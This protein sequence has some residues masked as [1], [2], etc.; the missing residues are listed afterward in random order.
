MS[1]RSPQSDETPTDAAPL[2]DDRRPLEELLASR[3][4]LAEAQRIARVGSWDWNIAEGSLVWSDEIY[5]IFGLEPQQFGATYEA[6]LEYVHSD[7]REKVEQAV[8]AALKDAAHYS[9]EHRVVRPDGEERVVHERGEVQFD[10]AG[11]PVHM[12]GTVQDITERKRLEKEREVEEPKAREEELQ[13]LNERLAESDRR[14]RR[15]IEANVA[16]IFVVEDDHLLEANDAFLGMVGYS[17]EDMESGRLDW[18]AMTPPEWAHTIEPG[19]EQLIT[20]GSTKP[21][22]KEYFRKDGS[23]VPILLGATLLDL[24]PLRWMCFVLDLSERKAAE[25]ERER[26]LTRTQALQKL[27]AGLALAVSPRDVLDVAMTS[28]LAALGADGGSL[29]LLSDDGQRVEA[30]YVGLSEE[31]AAT[32]AVYPIDSPLP[33]ATS[34]KENIAIWLESLE[35]T[36]AEYPETVEVLKATGSEA[37]ISLPLETDGKAFGFLGARFREARRF[38]E[39]DRALALTLAEQCSQ[40]LARA[41]LFEERQQALVRSRALQEVSAGLATSV[42]SDD[43][44]EIVFDKGFAAF[45]ASGGSLG[46]ITPERDGLEISYAGVTGGFSGGF[47]QVGIDEDLPASRCAREGVSLWYGTLDRLRAEFELAADVMETAGVKSILYSPLVVNQETIGYIGAHFGEE[48]ATTEKDRAFAKAVA[49]QCA[50][51]LLR[52]RLFDQRE[53]AFLRTQALQSVSAGM[54]AAITPEQVLDVVFSDALTALGAE[55][56]ALGLLDADGNTL[57]STRTGLPEDVVDRFAVTSIDEGL[58]QTD[59]VR[60]GREIWYRSLAEYAEDYPEMAGITDRAG[61][62]TVFALP[63]RAEGESIGYLAA[64]FR[65]KRDFSEGDRAFARAVAEQCS[66]AVARARLYEQREDALKRTQ[67]LQRVSAGLTRATTL[68]QVGEVIE[69]EVFPMLGVKAGSVGILDEEGEHLRL[70][71]GGWESRLVGRF[72]VVPLEAD[73]PGPACVRESRAS[74]YR[75]SAE[76]V[77]AFTEFPAKAVG[78]AGLE[79][80]FFLPLETTGEAFGFLSG[81]FGEQREFDQGDRRFFETV[82]EQCAQALA[83]ARFHDELNESLARTDALQRVSNELSRA[84]RIGDFLRVAF[85]EA[86]S[87]LAVDA[88][89]LGLASSDR[90]KVTIEHAGAET[91]G[92]EVTIDDPTS[93]GAFSVRTGEELWFESLEEMRADYPLAAELT[94]NAGGRT[95]FYLPLKLGSEGETIG[96]LSGRFDRPRRFDQK[97]RAFARS[98]VGR[99][100]QALVRARLYEERERTLAQTR[101]LEAVNAALARA[102]TPAEV[103]QVIFEHAFKVL[104]ASAS[105]LG[106][107]GENGKQIELITVGFPEHV[108]QAFPFIDIEDERPGPA[109]MK[110]GKPRWYASAEELLAEFPSMNEV[111]RDAWEAAFFIPLRAG[112][113]TLGYI[114]GYFEEAKIFDQSDRLFAQT[115][116]SQCAQALVRA[117]LFEERSERAEAALVLERVGDGIFRLDGKGRITTWNPAAARMTGIAVSHALGKRIGEILEDWDNPSRRIELVPPGEPAPRQSLPFNLGG[118]ELWLSI[119]GVRLP[120]GAVYAFHD[121]TAEHELERRQRDFIATVSHELRTPLASVYGVLCTLQRRELDTDTRDLML[122]VAIEQGDRLRRL[123]EEILI[124]SEVDATDLRMR[125]L[126]VD[127]AKIARSVVD[128]A[129][130]GLPAG[131]ALALTAPASLPPLHADPDRLQ[132]VLSNVIDNAIKFSPDGGTIRVEVSASQERIVFVVSDQGIGIPALERERIFERFY[133]LDPEQTK[134]IGG[135]GLGLFICRELVERMGGVIAADAAEG[136]GTG[137]RIELPR[138][139]RHGESGGDLAGR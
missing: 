29:G 69:S 43:V 12:L 135:T 19:Y 13:A 35:M 5:R 7:D 138:E 116:A 32:V 67:I 58:P 85:G 132:Q 74:W 127:P 31:V 52:A 70:T 82:A 71:M 10:H 49:E 133:R 66:Q 124:A 75:A 44:L 104:G 73:L 60:Y 68:E 62:K 108:A 72:Q 96:F 89:E 4:S 25:D 20:T 23:R 40:A 36:R 59:C 109:S 65:E 53:Q 79:A 16:G 129:L 55:G 111:I 26:A 14:L 77:S 37:L 45:G 38:S 48:E 87:A 78:E 121:V 81:F 130:P 86:L 50:Q 122:K 83:R 105:G 27:S 39:E 110:S 84:V 139:R 22:E 125:D 98:V 99:S 41:S 76:L 2:I 117:R 42:T 91:D 24:E 136:G 103:G 54:A 18:K 46:L 3:E 118:L 90:A 126:S 92:V 128:A 137:F 102:A 123:V 6:F 115:I 88:V 113:E 15:L 80:A 11:K 95:V 8:A 119:S 56:G 28:G 21:F 93:P 17:R 57:R 107:L 61:F 1:K 9:V 101:A 114:S 94:E 134:G 30:E 63:L 120:N 51:A 47:S 100:A 106:L 131:T 34:V 112:Q 64:R 33:A 97:E